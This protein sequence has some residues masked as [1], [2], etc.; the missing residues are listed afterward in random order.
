MADVVKLRVVRFDERM[1][2]HTWE[3]FHDEELRRLTGGRLLSREEQHA[4]FDQIPSRPDYRIWGVEGDGEPVAVFGFKNIVWGDSGQLFIFIGREADRGR[5]IG[6][7]MSFNAAMKAGELGLARVWAGASNPR[8][9][10]SLV[11]WGWRDTG[12][13]T[14]RGDPIFEIPASSPVTTEGPPDD[15]ADDL[16]GARGGG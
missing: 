2:D 14:E 11:R 7:F 12:H 13:L 5:G 16:T 4:W 1:R 3:W 9:Q 10:E 15:G 6:R 8:L